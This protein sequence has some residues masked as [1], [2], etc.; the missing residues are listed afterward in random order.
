MIMAE[1]K[2]TIPTKCTNPTAELLCGGVR[3][4]PG[5]VKTLISCGFQA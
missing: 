3:L 2:A 4:C 5:M 1:Q